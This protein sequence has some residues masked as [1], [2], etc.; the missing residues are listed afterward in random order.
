MNAEE[1]LR[2]EARASNATPAPWH[3]ID[4]PWGDG[5]CVFTGNGDPHTGRLICA[6]EALLED[7]EVELYGERDVLA[8]LYFIAHARSDVPAL[9]AEVNRLRQELRGHCACVVKPQGKTEAIVESCKFHGDMAARVGQL[10]ANAKETADALER[11]IQHLAHSPYDL[12]CWET[13]A[14]AVETLRGSVGSDPA[15]EGP[16]G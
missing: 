4:Q 11:M 6:S 14:C 3:R 16:Q 13:L 8:D 5:T 9:C 15:G 2:I 7:T 12:T 1:L 10:E